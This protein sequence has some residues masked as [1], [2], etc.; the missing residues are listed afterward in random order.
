MLSS[1]EHRQ[2]D[3]GVLGASL[4][5]ALVIHCGLLLGALPHMLPVDAEE[6]EI[7]PA[8]EQADAP[9]DTPMRVTVRTHEDPVVPPKED[10]EVEPPEEKPLEPEEL[11]EP[12]ARRKIVEQVTNEVRPEEAN[13]VSPQD[14]S[15]PEETR[16]TETT[17]EDVI[18]SNEPPDKPDEAAGPEVD[19]NPDV[20]V[21][22]APNEPEQVAMAVNKP[23]A[24]LDPEPTDA[25]PKE[26]AHVHEPTESIDESSPLEA[27]E[28]SSKDDRPDTDVKVDPKKLFGQPSLSDYEKVL[29][30]NDPDP[31][32][33]E[34]TKKRR[35]LFRNLAERQKLVKGSLENFIVE[36]QPGNHTA[37]NAHR[38][39]Y[40]GYINS[41]HRRIHKRWADGF[42]ITIDTT[43]P[44]SDPLQ[45]PSLNTTLEF[46]IDASTGEFDAVNLVRSSGE[47][48]FDAEAVATAW[49]VGKRP[50]PPPQIVSPNGKIYLHWNFWRDGRQCGVMTVS[51]FLKKVDE[52]GRVISTETDRPD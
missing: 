30:K 11:E 1:L 42:L 15:T 36:I 48:M 29:G 21:E 19:P 50:N 31:S 24:T 5:I 13:Y 27:K 45:N 49:A 51:V 44:R 3:H 52:E 20:D 35:R 23:D 18:P 22:D 46:I 7:E 41:I 14:N 28:R 39:I 26:D 2:R 37:V 32:T 33:L 38:A 9:P 16:A 17:Y 25:K 40:A 47:Y 4:V 8:P 10:P 6:L 34:P 12:R 43:Y